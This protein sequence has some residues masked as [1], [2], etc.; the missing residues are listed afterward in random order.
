MP[1]GWCPKDVE[2]AFPLIKQNA[3][4][5]IKFDPPS[6]RWAK[7]YTIVQY[8]FCM[9]FG[10]L[11]IQS[12]YQ[13]EIWPKMI[14]WLIITLPLVTNGFILENRRYAKLVDGI[15]L[16]L[17]AGCLIL[18]GSELGSYLTSIFIAYLTL[19]FILNGLLILFASNENEII[20]PYL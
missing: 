17:S 5:Q 20:D 15:R 3:G 19:S 9:L 6:N 4:A 13:L 12:S 8:V 11:F 2:V 1:T 14:V 10:V 18:F 7:Y 16:I